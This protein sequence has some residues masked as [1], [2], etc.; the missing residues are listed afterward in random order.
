[1][2]NASASSADLAAVAGLWASLSPPSLAGRT[3]R[4]DN[5]WQPNRH[6][7]PQLT[8]ARDV[9]Q[10]DIAAQVID[11]LLHDTQAKAGSFSLRSGAAEE[12]LEDLIHVGRCDAGAVILDLQ[13]SCVVFST[14]RHIDCSAPGREAK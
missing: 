6:K 12:G 10:R 13:D 1:M 9:L 8:C 14:N 3:V 11:N 7:E 5:N 4:P 2:C